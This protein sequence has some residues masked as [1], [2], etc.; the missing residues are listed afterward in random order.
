[1]SPA[2]RSERGP[3]AEYY[4]VRAAQIVADCAAEDIARFGYRF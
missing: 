3:Y 4:D 1:V 2:N